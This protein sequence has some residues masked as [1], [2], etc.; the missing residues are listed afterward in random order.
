LS[1]AIVWDPNTPQPGIPG[2]WQVFLKT[3]DFIE[4][5]P[6]G[7]FLFIEE[8]P[9]SIDNGLFVLDPEGYPNKPAQWGWV[10]WP[11]NYHNN[12]ACLSFADGHAETHSWRDERTTPPYVRNAYCWNVLNFSTPGNAD[13]FWL[14]DHATR[15][16]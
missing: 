12:A 13:V 15:P 5:G 1:S 2:Q 11:A 3:T 10:N 16:K 9:D 14:I 8:R 7:T 4:P 6:A